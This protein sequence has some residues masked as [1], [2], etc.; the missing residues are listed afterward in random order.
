MVAMDVV[1]CD[2]GCGDHGDCCDDLH[3]DWLGDRRH[4]GGL[5]FQP[6][7]LYD[8]EDYCSDFSVCASFGLRPLQLGWRPRL[9]S[10]EAEPS[11]ESV[12]AELIELPK[13]GEK[14]HF[15]SPDMQI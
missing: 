15:R 10:L 11:M 3:D 4:R 13:V 6:A 8:H 7:H 12:Q 9:Q 14:K 1:D 2:G 5:R